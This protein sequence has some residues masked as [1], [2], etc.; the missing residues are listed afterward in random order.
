MSP[1]AEALESG[2]LS[3]CSFPS[4]NRKSLKMDSERM[5]A[6]HDKKQLGPWAYETDSFSLHFDDTKTEL[7]LC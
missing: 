6:P 3:P 5:A 7:L 2:V 4:A 1:Q